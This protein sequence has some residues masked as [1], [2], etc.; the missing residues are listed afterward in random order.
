[1]YAIHAY[2]K[3]ES[4]TENEIALLNK[5]EK[6]YKDTIV[7]AKNYSILMNKA[8]DKYS[9]VYSELEKKFSDC[10]SVKFVNLMN[11]FKEKKQDTYVDNIHYTPHGNYIIA[12]K[13]E[14][15]VN[16]LEQ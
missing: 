2:S 13:F 11:A 8:F 4:L 7:N 16:S 1:M 12:K 5:F 14:G 6:R 3:E 15:I 10:D 9:K